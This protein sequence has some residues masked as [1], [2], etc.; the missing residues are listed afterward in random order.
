MKK[1]IIS[2]LIL[3]VFT[4]SCHSPKKT[5]NNDT[6]ILSDED[7]ISDE[8]LDE[9]IAEPDEDEKVDD[10]DENTSDDSG[11]FEN[12]SVENEPT[13]V[14]TNTGLEWQLT[15]SEKMIPDEYGCP[16]G[17]YC[18]YAAQYCEN[19]NYGGH[20]DW[21]VPSISELFSIVDLEK[22]DP[23]MNTNYFRNIPAGYFLSSSLSEEI[24]FPDAE[25][26]FF[27]DLKACVWSI[28][29]YDGSSVFCPTDKDYYVR[30]VRGEKKTS[31]TESYDESSAKLAAVK[32]NG[33]SVTLINPEDNSL[34]QLQ[35]VSK[36]T[37]KQASTYCD[38]L[39]LSGL[40]NWRLPD[41]NELLAAFPPCEDYLLGFYTGPYGYY[42]TFYSKYYWSS[43]SYSAD[44]ENA[45]LVNYG[46]NYEENYEA[47]CGGKAHLDTYWNKEKTSSDV[48]TRCVTENPCS[49]GEVWNGETCIANKCDPNPCKQMLLEEERK[50]VVTADEEA[51]YHCECSK[52]SFWN[53]DEKRCIRTCGG[54]NP[55]I[56]YSNSDRQC[57]EDK[58][59][60]FYC[61]C[62]EG[63]LWDSSERDCL[64]N[65]AYNDND[66][67]MSD[68]DSD[69]SETP[70][71]TNDADGL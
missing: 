11:M 59:G 54:T 47:E 30:C 2:I 49:K 44:S 6:D 27:Y 55:C 13:I 14:D 66:N 10:A 23:A 24:D 29:F 53:S 15:F 7:V 61:G 25:N 34:W 69:S 3:M 56:Y 26:P 60:E 52:N 40:S 9:D 4:V 19:L 16:A 71:E 35:P 65:A 39:N 28:D 48:Y 51:G 36:Q 68:A 46:E 37:W 42:Q 45:W 58:R 50:C 41:K 1:L 32:T 17:G 43:S 38:E 62:K 8:D 18:S 22:Y 20:N 57:Y 70:D 67:E 33:K 63:Y 12:N 64:K 5:E 21:R 31:S